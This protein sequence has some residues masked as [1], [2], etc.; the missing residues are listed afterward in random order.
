MGIRVRL[1]YR[2]MQLQLAVMVDGAKSRFLPK[3]PTLLLKSSRNAVTIMLPGQTRM[4]HKRSGQLRPPPHP[5]EPGPQGRGQ[6]RQGRPA[7]VRQFPPFD[8]VRNRHWRVA[9]SGPSM[10]SPRAVLT[11]IQARPT[12]WFRHIGVIRRLGPERVPEP[13]R[14]TAPPTAFAVFRRPATKRLCCIEESILSRKQDRYP[15]RGWRQCLV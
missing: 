9:S 8:A 14:Y 1:P 13:S 3:M 15:P 7:V 6:R 5:A 11:V 12:S 10:M 4:T 2:L